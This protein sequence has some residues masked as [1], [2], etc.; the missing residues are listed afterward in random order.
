MFSVG[1]GT[2]SEDELL[3]RLGLGEVRRLVDIRTAP[4]SRRHPHLGRDRLEQWLPAAGVAYRWEPR[5]GG[6]RRPAPASPDVVWQNASFR[7]YAGHLRTEA[8]QA[9]LA[10]LLADGV[11]APTA[12]LCSET[13]W[14]RCHRRLVADALVLLHGVEVQHLMPG[15]VSPHRP[16]TGA[17]R[18]ADVLVY[19]DVEAAGRPARP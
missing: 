12:F 9:A 13:V 7:G 1:H 3:E 11:A 10:D 17:R 14:W 18:D 5:L 8:A 2:A 19:D 6:F 15:R 4:G 16:T